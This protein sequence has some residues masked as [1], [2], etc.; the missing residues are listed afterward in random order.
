VLV[1]TPDD[2]LKPSSLLEEES[3][4]RQQIEQI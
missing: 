1:V 3:D 4:E 2:L